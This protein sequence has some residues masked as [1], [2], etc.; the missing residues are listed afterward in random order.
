MHFLLNN[1]DNC[2]EIENIRKSFH[3]NIKRNE[4]QSSTCEEQEKEV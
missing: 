2:N 4:K 3:L 1:E